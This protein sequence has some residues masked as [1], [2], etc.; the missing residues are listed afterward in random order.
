MLMHYLEHK[1]PGPAAFLDESAVGMLIANH[2]DEKLPR[3]L[4]F[5]KETEALRSHAEDTP[6]SVVALGRA[7]SL[8]N[9]SSATPQQAMR[10]SGLVRCAL[11]L[12]MQCN[13]PIV[14]LDDKFG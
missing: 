1:D 8:L 13:L 10:P 2:L 14:S 5:M 11:R 3:F 6:E 9:A 4:D 12:L 7:H